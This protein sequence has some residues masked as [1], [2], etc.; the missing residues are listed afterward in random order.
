MLC[1]AFRF[2]RGGSGSHQ[3]PPAASGCTADVVALRVYG[4]RDSVRAV[5]KFR[6]RFV[7]LKSVYRFFI[8][9]ISCTST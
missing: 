2:S 7:D 8:C 4:R 3:P 5:S 1:N 6:Q 9:S